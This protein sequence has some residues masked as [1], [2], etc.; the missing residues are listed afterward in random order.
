[1]LQDKIKSI[2]DEASKAMQL[3]ANLKELYDCK[4]KYLG[5]SG[6]LSLLMRDMGEVPKE[7]R[8]VIGKWMNEAKVALES[9]Y[10]EKEKNL[11][12]KELDSKLL[13]EKLDMTLPGSKRGMGNQHPITTVIQEVTAI[14]QR[15]GFSV[16]LGPLIESDRNNFEALNIPQDHPARDMQ[17]TFYIDKQHVLRTHTSP[18]QI[19]TMELEKP[20]IRIVA[21]GTVFRCDSDQT[22]LPQFHQIEGLLIDKKV[23]MAD[24][25]GT[26]AYFMRELFGA[27][28]KIRLRPSFFPF[29]EPSAEFDCS[30]PKCAGR[31]CGLCK[32][33]GWLEMG[34]CGLVHPEVFRHCKIAYPE[35]QGFAF[36]FGIERMAIVKYGIDDIRLMVENDMRF[37]EQF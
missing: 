30:C 31:G 22:H 9:I 32:N 33:T 13:S 37:L 8:P 27:K 28:T 14:L 11:K 18:V 35:W 5:K 4:V 20:P 1:M 34:G 10:D 24:L 16:R 21:P 6:A 36:G 15:L 26:I 3:A 12:Q 7:Q 17:D 25:K 2:Q 19:R 23:S 29:T